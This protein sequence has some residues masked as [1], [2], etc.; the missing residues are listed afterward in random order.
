MFALAAACLLMTVRPAAKAEEY[1]RDI[2][3]IAAE[4]GRDAQALIEL[5]R[6][7]WEAVTR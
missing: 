7:D 6:I 4:I 3:Y 5:K 2:E 1:R